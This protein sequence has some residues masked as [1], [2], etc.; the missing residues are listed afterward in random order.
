MQLEPIRLLSHPATA[1]SDANIWVEIFSTAQVTGLAASD[2]IIL[3]GCATNNLVPIRRYDANTNPPTLPVWRLQVGIPNNNRGTLTIILPEDSITQGNKLARNQF[4]F[5][6]VTSSS[7]VVAP[8]AT[9]T[10]SNRV[11]TGTEA[12]IPISFNKNVTEFT[13]DDLEIS[14]YKPDPNSDYNWSYSI[15]N[16]EWE[17]TLGTAVSTLS[18]GSI[19]IG[20][21]LTNIT[22]SRTQK[23]NPGD[24]GS[25]SKWII[26][27]NN[28]IA[29]LSDQN[30]TIS[31][32]T[33]VQN[34]VRANSAS[35]T[36]KIMTPI[37]ASGT[38]NIALTDGSVLAT[39][40][41]ITR[42]PI[43]PQNSGSFGFDTRGISLS[44]IL[45]SATFDLPTGTQTGATS[46]ITVNWSTRVF[47]FTNADTDIVISGG[48]TRNSLLA[49]DWAITLDSTVTS[50]SSVTVTGHTVSSI[51]R[52][53]RGPDDPNPSDRWIIRLSTAID[54]LQTSEVTSPS[55]SSVESADQTYTIR[56]N[57]PSSG[58]GAITA[59]IQENVATAV[60]DTT[61]SGP[62][63]PQNSGSYTYDRTPESRFTIPP[64]AIFTLPTGTQ[65]GA[66][67]EIEM[68]FGEKVYN[69]IR[70][71]IAITGGGSL[72]SS[73][74]NGYDIELAEAR[75]SLDSSEV[76]V[77]GYTVS[78]VERGRLAPLSGNTQYWRINL[79]DTAPNIQTI[80]T[81][82]GGSNANQRTISA[83]NPSGSL[84]N[85]VINNP[86]TGSGTINATLAKNAVT[87]VDDDTEGPELPQS[88]GSY[89]YDMNPSS[90][91]TPF[92]TI[93][94]GSFDP[95]SRSG[96]PH[97]TI[98]FYAYWNNISAGQLSEFQSD[99]VSV[100][101]SGIGTATVNPNQGG[102]FPISVAL[103]TAN[104]TGTMR[105]RIAANAV[106][107]SRE[108]TSSCI[109]FDNRA[110]VTAKPSVIISS[111]S[112][113]PTAT[114]SGVY[115]KVS[116]Y[117]Y[118]THA[119]EAQLLTLPNSKLTINKEPGSSLSATAAFEDL[120]NV[121]SSLA[122]PITISINTQNVNEDIS[123]TI[124]ANAIGDS[125]NIATTSACVHVDNRPV[126]N[127]KPSVIINGGSFNSS[128]VDTTVNPNIHGKAYFYS[129][130]INTDITQL[131]TLTSAKLT[132][133]TETGSSLQA[134]AAF[135][136]ILINAPS[137]GIPITVSINTQNVNEDI[138]V[139]IEANAVGNSTNL[140]TTSSCVHIDNRPVTA[141][142][143]SV[144]ISSGSFDPTAT[145]S[146]IYGKVSFYSY[147]TNT[148]EA[149]LLT[150][151]NSKLTVNK[152]HGSSLSADA[153]FEDLVNVASSLA[154]PI[155]IS[156]NTQ[157]VNEDISVTIEADAVGNSTNIATT[158][159]CVHI[160]N[161]PVTNPKP[162]V[163]INGGS[164]NS[165]VVDTTVNP[166]IHG[167]AYFYSR[168]INTDITQLNT[169]TSAK[170]TVNTETGSSLQA[171]AAFENILINAPSF[172][173]PITVSINTQN[174]NEDISVTIEA[175]AVGNSTNLATTSSCVYI[176][177]RA[178][179]GETIP[180]A[181]ISAGYFDKLSLSISFYISWADTDGDT[182]DTAFPPI[183]STTPNT[184][185]IG[186]PPKITW[187][188]ASGDDL[189]GI[190]A[191]LQAREELTYKLI[192]SNL[193]EN[194]NSYLTI[195]VES[196]AVESSL[197]VISSPVDYDTR[198]KIQYYIGDG[199]NSSEEL[200]ILPLDTPFRQREIWI[201]ITSWAESA[202]VLNAAKFYIANGRVRLGLLERGNI[203]RFKE[204]DASLFPTQPHE[205]RVP[206]TLPA[207]SSGYLTVTIPEDIIEG[208][209]HSVS[210][211]FSFDTN[212]IVTKYP[213][214]TFRVPTDLQTERL[215]DIG[216]DFQSRVVGLTGFDFT[217]NGVSPRPTARILGRDFEIT[218]AE[219]ESETPEIT[220]RS[221]APG[222]PIISNIIRSP[223]EVPEGVTNKWI[224]QFNQPIPV[225]LL[226]SDLVFE[227]GELTG[228]PELID[229]SYIFQIFNPPNSAGRIDITLREDAVEDIGTQLQGPEED[230]QSDSYAF[231]TFDGPAFVE[232]VNIPSGRLNAPF[233]VDIRFNRP[234]SKISLGSFIFDGLNLELPDLYSPTYTASGKHNGWAL[235]SSF[236]AYEF[237]PIALIRG[238]RD[239][240]YLVGNTRKALID[241]RFK[242]ND[243]DPTLQDLERGQ[244]INSSLKNFKGIFYHGI[245]EETDPRG[246][247]WDTNSRQLYM[248]GASNNSLYQMLWTAGGIQKR[249]TCETTKGFGANEI[250]PRGLTY[251]EDF[252]S[253][254]NSENTGTLYMIGASNNRLYTMD[255]TDG[256]ATP[257]NN[258][259]FGNRETDPRGLIWKPDLN[260]DGEPQNT[261]FLYMFGASTNSLYTININ[262]G[263]DIRV[264]NNSNTDFPTVQG[265]ALIEDEI[266]L[267][268][269]DEK[270][271]LYKL[272]IEE[273]EITK[274]TRVQESMPV[275]GNQYRYQDFQ[276]RFDKPDED[277]SGTLNLSLKAN[278]VE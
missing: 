56:V 140:A 43:L 130:W 262:D 36:I 47:G 177:N 182:L 183:T 89:A 202:L 137:F 30:L 204:Y 191:A 12:I 85:L 26:F 239:R 115:G 215:T 235:L 109:Y 59:T 218:L 263:T 270:G 152:E 33:V 237:E 25:V 77:T 81:L 233:N 99:D 206:I 184:A 16:R 45:P 240:Y 221:V 198:D 201:E 271:S 5:N 128:V 132:V 73:R 75:G 46:D 11:I 251:K 188:G 87:T 14:G 93:N 64:S 9:F 224:I 135:E 114:S 133:N 4:E 252:D 102:A 223:R 41:N 249:I 186:S 121:A 162:S 72:N 24:T 226:N 255:T 156:I 95:T 275:H 2:F 124:E 117:S 138:S 116:F 189:T 254:G 55:I 123:V 70:S 129:R 35:Y 243:R 219:A 111:G 176:D 179:V 231:N 213:S 68:N 208:G 118:W 185:N 94:S 49:Q 170:L 253:S 175:N 236:K 211:A 149:Q 57:N 105:I 203:K 40:D 101:P 222:E 103:S 18:S 276:L 267:I 91:S 167:K 145:T 205:W 10:I 161:R 147:W 76:T 193:P 84:Y 165:S 150:L 65:T 178:V 217:I 108:V 82:T 151:P 250:D 23:L 37:N 69:F 228:S 110:S 141:A 1:I 207:T 180:S 97:G 126:T 160:D 258:S 277:S 53:P 225:P 148:T 52:D 90:E 79:S 86:S 273:L 139:T 194:K 144:V 232:S 272:D 51:D 29:L 230:Q 71:D 50:L 32:N 146:R 261:G 58:S 174:V 83:A 169:L 78:T 67:S 260:K 278:S 172:G 19:T 120:V 212:I 21:G 153:A 210:K 257:V 256:I 155:T 98:Y 143:P 200:D 74:S 159:A 190:S 266:Y 168:W 22:V 264:P 214:A 259:Y 246:L 122:V 158:S 107:S 268:S 187:S 131:N 166:N 247:A 163:I 173:I 31:G 92:V 113:D 164:F 112:F 8:F 60:N 242:N 15:V 269:P 6:R 238:Y 234:I 119:T 181:I 17:I 154:V 88:S 61:A 241:I 220:L 13:A 216:V 136:N 134:S 125:T 274:I 20:N 157:N 27:L 265:L 127:P 197:Q 248:I 244:V 42:G 34:S 62:E 199:Y 39:D 104:S 66:T 38:I 106:G 48:G 7:V 3:N 63:I 195:T 171:S 100:L 142:K 28:E 229:K 80:T 96:A 54:A 245:P 196:N 44:S 227:D 192:L 209:N